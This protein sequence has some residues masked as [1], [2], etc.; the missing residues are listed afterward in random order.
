MKQQEELAVASPP[1]CSI[2]RRGF[3]SP[4]AR[5]LK[6]FQSS[7]DLPFLR[8][9]TATVYSGAR[10]LKQLAMVDANLAT[11][12]K[13]VKSTLQTEAT[14][15]QQEIIR[16]AP[17]ETVVPPVNILDCLASIGNYTTVFDVT[18]GHKDSFKHPSDP[19][20]LEN[21]VSFPLGSPDLSFNLDAY[22]K[23]GTVPPGGL[24]YPRYKV[25]SVSF[26]ASDVELHCLHSDM[27]FGPRQSHKDRFRRGSW[28]REGTEEPVFFPK[29][30][31]VLDWK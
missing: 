28:L 20:V 27:H 9:F 29:G 17:P 3:V 8:I 19:P 15:R 21:K 18:F 14:A 5:V 7:T 2:P 24:A 23:E 22:L 30:A 31:A 25:A 4:G 10:I 11:S 6:E 16:T 1:H 12:Q 26:A 13:V